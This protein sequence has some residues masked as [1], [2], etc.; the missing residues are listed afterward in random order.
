MK[1]LV[2]NDD[3][4]GSEG[5]HALHDMLRDQDFGEVFMVA[6][7]W[8]YSGY[9]SAL[10]LGE[11]LPPLNQIAPSK[12]AL[13]G[14]PADCAYVGLHSDLGKDV[15]VM[16]S[17]INPGDN[18]STDIMS[19]GTIGA[20]LQG[21]FLPYPPIAI[22]MVINPGR[23]CVDHLMTGAQVACQIVK[24]FLNNKQ[25]WQRVANSI[26]NVNVPDLPPEEIRG[27]KW[28][29]LVLRHK[30]TACHHDEQGRI[31]LGARGRVDYNLPDTD[32]S[33]VREGFV[34]ITPLKQDLTDY[35]QLEEVKRYGY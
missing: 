29:R 4:W 26:L 31:W 9:G 24:M 14:T 6:P 15:Q 10:T 17:G 2:T 11:S 1:I 30:S 32:V 35:A 5:I 8:D 33:A 16:V 12:Y 13:E 21:R 18:L 25:K 19:S 7:E 20:A 22:S 28:T 34:S 27:Y 23:P 3:G